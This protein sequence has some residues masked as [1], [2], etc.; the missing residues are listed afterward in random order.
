LEKRAVGGFPEA[1][2]RSLSRGPTLVNELARALVDA[3]FPDSIRDDLLGELGL[4][5]CEGE[6]AVR[7]AGFRLAVIQAYEHRCTIC[8]YDAKLGRCD[9]G[10]EAAHILWHQAGGPD[11]VQNGLALCCLHHKAFDRG[12]VSIDN[13]LRVVV[14]ADL[15]GGD[16]AQ[17]WFF[18]F[19]GERLRPPHSPS[20]LPEARFLAWH[21]RE[22][23]RGPA[24]D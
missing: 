1:I 22:V 14:S 15:Y 2:Y 13:A 17:D 3:H 24:R 6:A 20:L 10:L 7:D 12:A 5:P 23:F 9:V 16:S 4:D 8:G 21:R 19:K 18:R 11:I